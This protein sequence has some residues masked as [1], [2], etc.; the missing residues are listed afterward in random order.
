MEQVHIL[1][2]DTDQQSNQNLAKALE[3]EKFM[4]HMAQDAKA[5]L[6][7]LAQ[8]NS[9]QVIVLCL[10]LAANNDFALLQEIKNLYPEKQVLLSSEHE[11]HEHLSDTSTIGTYTILPKPIDVA[12][13]IESLGL[14]I[15]DKVESALVAAS[16]AQA[17]AFEE[18]NQIV[19][20]IE[21]ME[22]IQEKAEEVLKKAAY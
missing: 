14:N 22:E 10:D 16:L 1:L 5:M 13:L 11:E 3:A 4:V 2:V 19:E 8:D 21:S 6:E 17:G 20:E 18:A 12:L 9:P 15:A 7:K